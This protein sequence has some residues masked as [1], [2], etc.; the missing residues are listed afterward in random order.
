[1]YKHPKS[2]TFQKQNCLKSNFIRRISI[3]LIFLFTTAVVSAQTLVTGKV[4]NAFDQTVIPGVSVVVKG[5]TIGTSTDIEGNYSISVPDG[6]VLVF[7]FLGMKTQEILVTSNVLDVALEE[8]L[9]GLDEVV[10]IAY[11]TVKKSAYTGSAAQ[12]NN[13]TIKER[14]ITHLAQAIEGTL[15]VQTTSGTGQPGEGPDIRIRGT[16]SLNLDSDPLYVVDGVIFS[17]FINSINTNDIESISILKDAAATALYGNKAANGVVMITTKKGRKGQ[18]QLSIDASTGLVTRAFPE[19]ERVGV[20]D[21]YVLMWEAIRNDRLYNVGDDE[22]TAN[23]YATDELINE[24]GYNILN[25]ADDEIVTNGVFNPNASILDGY[26]DDLDWQKD[27]MKTGIRQNYD[28]NYSGGSDRADYYV[29]LGYQD[30]EGFTIESNFK[31]ITGRANVNYQAN[32]WFKTG[33]NISGSSSEA[34]Q[35]QD[36]GS[37]SYRNP[38][39]TARSIGP[40]YPVHEHDPVTGEYILDDDGNKVYDIDDH[41]PGGAS[42]GRHII[43]E[44][45]WNSDIDEITS[46]SAK[47]FGEITF[48]KD[49]SFRANVGYD[50]RHFYN[51]YYDNHLVGDGAPGGRAGR[52]YTSRTNWTFN[53]LLNYEKTFNFGDVKLLFGHESTQ[54]NYSIFWGDKVEQV[55]TDNTELVN[56]VTITDLDSYSNKY[57]TEG[58]FSR[59]DYNYLGKYFLSGSFRMDGSSK[60]AKDYR[61]GSFWSISAAWKMDQESFIKNL[62]WFDMLKL[63][64]SYGQVGNDA[65]LS[66]YAY[67]SLYDLGYNNGAEAGIIQGA[68]ASVETQWESQNSFDLALEFAAFGRLQGSIG[69]YKKITSELIFYVPVPYSSGG[70]E[71]AQNIGELFNSGFE[72]ELRADVVKTQDWNWNVGASIYTNHNEITEMPQEEIINGT[73]KYMVGKSI[74][75]YWLRDWYGVD[76][77]DGMALYVADKEHRSDWATDSD[78][79]IQGIDTLTINSNKAMYHYAGSAFPSLQGSVTNTVRY[80]GF[81]LSLLLTYSIGGYVYDDAHANIMS[82]GTFGEAI[83]TEMLDRWQEPGDNTDIP[84]MDAGNTSYFG[85]ASDRW[86]ISAS[87]LNIKRLTLGYNLP[88]KY[89]DYVGLA[90]ARL[91]ASAEN[92]YLFSNREGMMVSQ[93]FS[94]VTSNV[95]PPARIVTIGINVKF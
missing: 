94:G 73:K 1:M 46:V 92:L 42:T 11:G 87:Y 83:S 93:N 76:S 16:G 57:T 65:G 31:R 79:R 40:I 86:L 69:Y 52:E 81:D 91:Y 33:L 67:Q 39:R 54:E 89:T 50:E 90:D 23:Q 66:R 71:I 26:K 82:S 84:R 12:I 5:T 15:G 47:T 77:D 17:G 24:L 28:L 68:L 64:A 48:L 95:Y 43:A 80:K 88:E 59:L 51:S 55:V 22:T 13:E 3:F 14:P 78:I 19:Y 74:Y 49:F 56:F 41:R 9:L 7:S 53:Q 61:W 45:K 6:Q 20:E 10:V 8:D 72:L 4:T 37:S 70:D 32:D 63:R 44:T 21:Y 18:G 38:F 85:A 60:F 30:L 62:G 58:Y 35:A 36:A 34:K 29:S 2:T 27:L 75:D 25:V